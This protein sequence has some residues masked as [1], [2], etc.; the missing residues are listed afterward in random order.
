MA[1]R[2]VEWQTVAQV[3]LQHRHHQALNIVQHHVG[4]V[5]LGIE[6]GDCIRAVGQHS[7]TNPHMLCFPH[8][9]IHTV[10]VYVPAVSHL[11]TTLGLTT[12]QVRL[13]HRFGHHQGKVAVRSVTTTASVTD[14]ESCLLPRRGGVRV[15]RPMHH[16]A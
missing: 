4:I 11:Q 12:R 2:S 7:Q 14:T 16:Q 13:G 1:R 9:L 6:T 5:Y 8:H 3:H 10:A 15:G